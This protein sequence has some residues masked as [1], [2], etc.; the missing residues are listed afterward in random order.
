M[1][2]NLKILLIEDNPG[3]VML[4]E[5]L[6]LDSKQFIFSITNAETLGAG[7]ELVQKDDFDIVLLDL[8]LPDSHGLDALTA[9]LEKV[10]HLPIVVITGLD[11]DE[12]GRKAI[13]MG[14][15][16]YIIKGLSSTR[17]FTDSIT[18]AIE[19][20]NILLELK[21]KDAEME[22]INAR[23]KHANHSKE[24][25]IALLSH[26]LR[27]PVEAVVS[28]LELMVDD[29]DNMGDETKKQMLNSCVN[30]GKSTLE[31]METL[32]NWARLQSNERKIQPQRTAL[33]TFI[34]KSMEPVRA[35]AASKNMI[36]RNQTSDDHCFYADKDMIATVIRN[37]LTN[38]VKFTPKNGTVTVKS[39][40]ASNGGVVVYVEDTG[41]GIDEKNI[42][43]IFDISA[44]FTTVGTEK[45]IG[46]GFGMILCKEF[47]EKNKGNME[48][49]SE[50]GKG[51]IV[52]IELPASN[53][54]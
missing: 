27:G 42:D 54:D 45:E 14:A 11:D 31:L 37:L 51:T 35:M 40:R 13:N 44:R 32:L 19:R 4:M 33:K 53:S 3:D 16:S 47:V 52:G 41:V 5:E 15:Q 2:Q 21:N 23:L 39:E 34:D 38:A 48:I 17:V 24:R 46:S 20:N 9:M 36:I 12:T 25:L 7:L 49:D 43:K 18:H 29:F 30:S 28:L 10:D 8:G 1:D 22:R 26:D 6:L 50:P